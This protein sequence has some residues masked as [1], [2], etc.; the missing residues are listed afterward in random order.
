MSF[1]S[2]E[3][4]INDKEILLGQTSVVKYVQMIHLHFTTMHITW[5]QKQRKRLAN[6]YFYE[7][8]QIHLKADT[9]INKNQ[10]ETGRYHI[11]ESEIN[12]GTIAKERYGDFTVCSPPGN[13]GS[14]AV[15]HLVLTGLKVNT[16]EFICFATKHPSRTFQLITRAPLQIPR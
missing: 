1:E 8:L 10:G 2:T 5:P 7:R 3:S 13:F 15:F 16:G 6:L 14:T 12:R 9:F 4:W 11:L